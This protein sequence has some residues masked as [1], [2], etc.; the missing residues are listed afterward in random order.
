MALTD[1]IIQE[2]QNKP[3]VNTEL[4][5]PGNIF[6]SKYKLIITPTN[7]DIIKASEFVLENA[8]LNK[9]GEPNS[10]TLFPSLFQ[11]T[12]INLETIPSDYI[13][14]VVFQDSTNL[15]NNPAWEA[16][17]DNQVFIWLYFGKSLTTPITNQDLQRSL[18][19]N[20]TRVE[21]VSIV[22]Q[23]ETI[24]ASVDN[25]GKKIKPTIKSINF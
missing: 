4:L 25:A 18:I 3:V 17:Q 19:P 24:E 15:K 5:T 14:K 9:T 1:Y 2:I 22:T 11:Y 21:T 8:T 23:T 10:F 20:I 16:R 6:P 7:N 12:Y 13:Y